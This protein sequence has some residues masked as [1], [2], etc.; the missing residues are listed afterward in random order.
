MYGARCM[1]CEDYIPQTAALQGNQH[2]RLWVRKNS[3]AEDPY[4]FPLLLPAL[5]M[6]YGDGT[7]D[8]RTRGRAE[9]GRRKA[10]RFC[11]SASRSRGRV[12]FEVRWSG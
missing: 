11:L 7:P 9:G 3:Y 8:A 10:L 1:K 12:G 6:V 2:E 5:R 4:A